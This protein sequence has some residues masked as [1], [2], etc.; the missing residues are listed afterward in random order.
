MR[1]A[2][3]LIPGL[4]RIGGAERQ[5][6]LLAHGLRR[7]GW[8]VT[9]VAL[10][11]TGGQAAADLRQ[12]QIGFT[13]LGF[14]K[15]LADPRGWLRFRRWLRRERPD[16]LHAH[17]PHA[18]WL[19][20]SARLWAPVP[21]LLDTI[22]T[23]ATG[24]W[25]RRLVYRLS[26]RLP[27]CVTAVSYT[28]AEAH[29]R[30]H[31]V[32]AHTLHVVPNGIDF[33]RFSPNPT[34]RKAV[35]TSIGA[36]DAFL[37]LAA[38]R[39]DPVKDYPV[40]LRAVAALPDDNWLL[41][42]GSGPLEAELKALCSHLDLDARV[43]F[44]GF[45]P[46]L[47]QWMQAADAFVLSSQWEGLPLALLEAAACELPIVA[48]DVPGT[49]EALECLETGCLVDPGDPAAL[50]SAML[51][52]TKRP[53]VQLHAMGVR[54]RHNAAPRFAIEAVLNQWETIYNELILGRKPPRPPAAASGTASRGH[55]EEPKLRVPAP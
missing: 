5:V 14:R 24:G 31:M 34:A 4:D 26:R 47:E 22:H 27:D 9:V 55:A 33:D 11:G 25:P 35:R 29:L 44:L 21:A 36:G 13:S 52:L 19:A 46:D 1:H 7:R 48:T 8:Q 28:A 30:A 50:A 37:W 41:I 32:S 53:P 3:I 12:D 17:L 18:A 6:L 40:L 23:T 45:R 54:A 38:G 42:A 15:G 49:R 20:R 16:V 2:G 51:D 10:S 43:R 39:L